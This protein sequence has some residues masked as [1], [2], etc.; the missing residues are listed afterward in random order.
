MKI[1][2][3]YLIGYVIT[4]KGINIRPIAVAV[5]RLFGLTKVE[6]IARANQSP[7]S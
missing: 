1:I 5:K 7:K 4:S 6:E 3:K 2:A